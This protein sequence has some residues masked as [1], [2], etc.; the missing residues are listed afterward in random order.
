MSKPL[1]VMVIQNL[2]AFYAF[3]MSWLLSFVEASVQ[4]SMRFEPE[5]YEDCEVTN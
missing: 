4:T 5:Y 2:L 1:P 3:A